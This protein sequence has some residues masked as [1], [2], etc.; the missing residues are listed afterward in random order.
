[1]DGTGGDRMQNDRTSIPTM[2]PKDLPK[3][4][5]RRTVLK[6]IGVGVVGSAALAGSA[7]AHDDNGTYGNGN[8]IGKFLNEE[9]LLKNRPIWDSG[10]ADRTGHDEV[11]VEVGTMTSIDVPEEMLPPG[12][13]EAPEEGPFAFTPRAVEI[14]PQ[15]TVTWEWTGNA[16]AL[17]PGE[18]WPHD[19]HSLDESGGTALFHSGPP[20][21]TGTF[22]YTFDEAGTY[23]YFCHPH[24]DPFTNDHPN[25][26]GMRGAV[27]VTDE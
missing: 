1:M 6:T 11:V 2:Q 15:T 25:L 17:M 26:F 13:E 24:G 3:R 14:S 22:E 8:A 4:A 12:V 19:V 23:L 9:A 10:V 16:F 18:P 21:G 20:Q 5:N 27:K 7:R